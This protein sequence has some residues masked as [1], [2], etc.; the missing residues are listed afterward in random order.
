[1]DAI[2][3]G[4][5][6]ETGVAL[7]IDQTEEGSPPDANMNGSSR[8]KAKRRKKKKKPEALCEEEE[9]TLDVAEKPTNEDQNPLSNIRIQ[10]DS[11]QQ[12]Q[13][14]CEKPEDPQSGFCWRLVED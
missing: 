12:A 14:S 3:L 11:C 6:P 2:S 13:D 8:K 9:K 1:M 7:H 5:I 10:E 4:T